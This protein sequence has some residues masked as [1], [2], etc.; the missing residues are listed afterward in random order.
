MTGEIS[1]KIPA[2]LYGTV[3]IDLRLHYNPNDPLAIRFAL[4]TAGQ[5]WYVARD[6]LGARLIGAGDDAIH[7]LEVCASKVGVAAEPELFR[8]V[9]TLRGSGRWPLAVPLFSL[10]HFVADTYLACPKAQERRLV[11]DELAGV[12]SFLQLAH[13]NEQS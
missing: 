7:Y 3:A 10:A 8:A 1:R 13:G 11:D 5:S 4:P 2:L 12:I 6:W 9:V